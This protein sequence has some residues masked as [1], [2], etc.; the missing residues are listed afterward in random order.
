[1]E[2]HLAQPPITTPA[3][4]VPVYGVGYAETDGNVSPVSA[5]APLPVSL[6]GGEL[7]APLTG[8]ASASMVAGPF[9]PAAGV[10]VTLVLD[11]DWQ[12]SVQV[13]RS[14]DGGTTRTP[15]TI[16]GATWARF[17]GNACEPV[18]EDRDPAATLWLNITLDAGTVTYRMGN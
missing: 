4:F 17:T 11:G 13:E 18:W 12:G 6:S 15:L 2:A 1:M 14:T 8:N 3:R 10:P 9:T 5:Q 7:P 16:D